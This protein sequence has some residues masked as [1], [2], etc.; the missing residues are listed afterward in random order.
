MLF[1]CLF[2]LIDQS[3]YCYFCSVM[4]SFCVLRDGQGIFFYTY[5]YI[6]ILGW[7]GG[8]LTLYSVAVKQCTLRQAWAAKRLFCLLWQTLKI[9]SLSLTSHLGCKL[10]SFLD[11]NTH[12]HAHTHAHT[13]IH[14]HRQVK[15]NEFCWRQT[16]LEETILFCLFFLERSR[17][18]VRVRPSHTWQR[19]LF[20]SPL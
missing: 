1:F 15:R 12:M 16:W 7:V 3:G 6:Y 19:Y 14:T 8:F 10:N 20:Q 17:P 2:V 4:R 5:I 11:L 13:H 9:G 18:T